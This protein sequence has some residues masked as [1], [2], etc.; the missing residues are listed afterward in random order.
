MTDASNPTGVF[1]A[2]SKAPWNLSH[3]VTLILN[4]L[5]QVEAA[6]ALSYP[7]PKNQGRHLGWWMTFRVAGPVL[8]GAIKSVIFRSRNEL[9]TDNAVD[10]VLRN[11]LGINSNNSQR[12]S[13]NPKVYLAFIAIQAIGPAVALLLPAPHRVQRTDGLRVQL[14]VDTPIGRE[15]KE[16]LKLF[17][18]KRVSE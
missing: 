16:T 13:I 14:Y 10:I 1:W 9:V 12:G 6:V 15:V 8:G 3:D 2:V 18:S 5:A 7:E 11:S 4:P 17:A